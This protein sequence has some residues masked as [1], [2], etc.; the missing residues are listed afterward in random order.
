MLAL[1]TLVM[2]MTLETHHFSRLRQKPRPLVLGLA[3]QWGLLPLLAWLLIVTLELP[4]TTAAALILI[5]AAPGG[6]TSNMFSFLADGDTALSVSLTAFVGLLAPLWM[7]VA[8][9]IQLPWLGIDSG[10]LAL[11]LGPTM[12]QLALICIVPV[13][14]GMMIRRYHRAWVDQHQPRLK[15]LVGF[16]FMLL[17]LAL[18]ARNLQQLPSLL[19]RSALAMLLLCALALSAGYLLARLARC[20]AASCR[21][22]AFEV[23]IQNGAIAILVAYSQLGSDELAMMALL[24][25]IMMNLPALALLAWF[26]ARTPA[27]LFSRQ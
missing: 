18:V 21:S 3:M 15:Q 2:G 1:M 8:I 11:P 13:V 12:A 26:R 20:P 6:A 23:G 24:Y 17:L 22:L 27:P 9:M 25:G 7:P 16:L 14:T 5:S 10:T 4:T 19:G